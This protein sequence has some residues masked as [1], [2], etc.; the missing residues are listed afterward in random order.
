MHR[1]G[2]V[3][4]SPGGTIGAGGLGS[5]G[6]KSQNSAPY[7]DPSTTPHSPCIRN[8]QPNV[9]AMETK[10]QC[11]ELGYDRNNKDLSSLTAAFEVVGATDPRG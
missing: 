4:G 6:G 9:D 11:K 7:D 2:G 1:G 8:R 3:G 10:V 5:G